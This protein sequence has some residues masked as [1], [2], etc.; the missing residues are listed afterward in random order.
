MKKVN[1]IFLISK[2]S[3]LYNDC[4]FLAD[5]AH[6]VTTRMAINA[7]NLGFISTNTSDEHGKRDYSAC[8]IINVDTMGIYSKL[9]LLKLSINIKTFLL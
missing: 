2:S 6:S 1:T 7:E 9:K 8:V 3:L 4:V 5:L